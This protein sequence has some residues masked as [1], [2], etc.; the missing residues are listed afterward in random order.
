MTDS[1]MTFPYDTF[2]PTHVGESTIPNAGRGLFAST[3]VEA[4]TA[5]GFFPGIVKPRLS[6]DLA[7]GYRMGSLD[8]DWAI[9]PDPSVT[10][11]L[12]LINE[13]SRGHQANVW[14]VKLAGHRCL[15][16]S[17]MAIAE[18]EELITCYGK[19]HA[20]LYQLPEV[21]DCTDPRCRRSRWHRTESGMDETWITALL[22]NAPERVRRALLNASPSR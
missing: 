19:N 21:H 4:F 16:F 9:E 18:G 12:H 3:A 15:F 20:R 2:V 10:P 22:E 14:Y 1:A 6:R 8:P 5:L 7:P 13:A 11:G 17:G